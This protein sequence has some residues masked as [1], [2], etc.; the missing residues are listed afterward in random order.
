MTKKRINKK[1]SPDLLLKILRKIKKRGYNLNPSTLE[2]I[3]P[4]LP[5]ALIYY[6][7]SVRKA[8]E[9]IGYDYSKEKKFKK[10]SLEN[11]VSEIWELKFAGESFSYKN[12]LDNHCGLLRAMERKL[13]SRGNALTFAGINPEIENLRKPRAEIE[14]LI[15]LVHHRKKLGMPV[16]IKALMDCGVN[17][18]RVVDICGSWDRLM[19]ICKLNPEEERA[20]QYWDLEKVINEAL[21]IWEK[22]HCFRSRFLKEKNSPLANAIY[23]DSNNVIPG[24]TG[25]EKMEYVVRAIGQDPDQVLRPPFE[26]WQSFERV[27]E[28]SQ[29]FW[30]THKKFYVRYLARKNPRLYGAIYGRSS[31]VP[32]E[33][34]RE[35]A[36]YV[37]RTLRLDPALVIKPPRRENWTLDE[38][39][40]EV[41]D[42]LKNRSYLNPEELKQ[43]RPKVY[44]AIYRK[45]SCVSGESGL[46]RLKYVVKMTEY[47]VSIIKLNK[48]RRDPW[49]INELVEEV[50]DYLKKHSYLAPT[51]FCKEKRNA[52]QAIYS[53]GSKIPGKE[54]LDR[55]KYVIEKAGYDISIVRLKKLTR[56]KWTK[57]ELVEEIK[58]YLKSHTHFDVG[59]FGREKKNVRGAI[60]KKNSC[61]PGETGIE[62]LKNVVEL[63]DFDPAITIKKHGR[64]ILL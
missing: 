41:Q 45:T 39:I 37:L 61:I 5:S 19:E 3:Y 28:E 57:D 31:C 60:C 15:A 52:Y 9:L 46:D 12:L 17:F 25:R 29:L 8:V 14:D 47:E 42:F 43:S 48:P 58:E 22:Y 4:S 6:F 50:V 62:R 27:I 49:A 40:S 34:G 51:E 53:K 64:F 38:L 56:K 24:K 11:I 7:R 35:R 44:T 54:G 36:K 30:N 16:N 13:E 33:S 32:G 55:L 1:W 26:D 21:V 20:L 23:V 10:R 59:E 18:A 63:A 2:S